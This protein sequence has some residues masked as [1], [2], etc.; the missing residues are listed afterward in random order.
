MNIT[1]N[2]KFNLPENT[3]RASQLPFNDNFL[4]LEQTILPSFVLNE[5]FAQEQVKLENLTNRVKTIEDNYVNSSVFTT[6]QNSMT[7]SLA[8]YYNKNEVDGFLKNYVKS[9]ELTTTLAS[10]VTTNTLNTTLANYVLASNND[11]VTNNSLNT[12]LKGYVQTNALSAYV[13]TAELSGYVTVEEYNKL[14][15]RVK[16]LEEPENA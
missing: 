16:A 3:D 10:Y 15:A 2:Y 11:Y 12:T 14:E 7:Q 4:K 6:Y 1:S 5:K 8:G 13:K 9:G